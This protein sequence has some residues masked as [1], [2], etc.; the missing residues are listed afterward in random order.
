MK[1]S[2]RPLHSPVK[3]PY[4]PLKKFLAGP[5]NQSGHFTEQEIIFA[6]HM[7]RISL[8]LSRSFGLSHL[9]CQGTEENY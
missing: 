3:T 8:Q 9:S 7:N 1:F 5:L 2:P 6:S 4:Y